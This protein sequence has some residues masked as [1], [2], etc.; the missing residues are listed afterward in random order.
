MRC[1]VAGGLGP[2]AGG[3]FVIRLSFH[4][5]FSLIQ[6]PNVKLKLAALA[7]GLLGCCATPAGAQHTH[8]PTPCGTPALHQRLLEHNPHYAAGFRRTQ[9]WLQAATQAELEA[10]RKTN[11]VYTIPVVFHVVYN[12]AAQNIPD[13]AI[14]EQVDILNADFRRMNS[15]AG[16]APAVFQAVAADAEIEF[17]LASLDPDG[18]ATTGI[19]RTQTSVA[20]FDPNQG[21]A[22]K[23]TAS[24]GVD[25]WPTDQ[26][27]NIWVC[28]LGGGLLGY[29]QFPADGQAET[30]GVVLVY[31]A[32]GVTGA[33]DP[34]DGGRTATHEVGHWLN[35]FHIW[36]DDNCGDDEVADTPPAQEA[37]YG[38]ETH[39]HRA[40]VCPGNTDGEMF[41]NYMDYGDDACLNLFTAGQKARMRAVLGAGGPRNSLLTSPACGP[42]S[43]RPG[44]AVD[45]LAL[46]AQPNPTNGWV[47]LTGLAATAA[48][49]R[50]QVVDA[51]GRTVHVAPPQPAAAGRFAAALDLSALPAGLYW[52]QVQAGQARQVVR[53]VR[54]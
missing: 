44:Q 33:Q 11:V 42:A 47:T 34:N 27:L 1:R 48:P 32:V 30:D 41:M 39:P 25:A 37:N 17:C 12:T 28:N 10:P 18:N 43:M 49:L 50:I 23:Y 13:A 20:E 22:I 19:T 38:C 9:A 40:G 15:D 46:T 7:L 54:H 53:V 45:A 36:G 21:E 29:A 6:M 8:H 4:F 26:Y 14:F 24:G 52:V 5:S 16:N 51:L 35:L 2:A 3:R 31:T